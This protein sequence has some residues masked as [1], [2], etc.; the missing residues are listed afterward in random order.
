VSG[1]A[2]E[3]CYALAPGHRLQWEEAQQ[4]WVILYPEGM[5]ILND[6]AA[7]TLRRCDGATPLAA[8]IDDLERV[9]GE[10]GLATDVLELVAAALEEGW[11]RPEPPAPAGV[12][13]T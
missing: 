3:W 2:L 1:S 12:P 13:A 6:S 11:L 8:V 5:V 7:E 4:A 9:Y 10:S